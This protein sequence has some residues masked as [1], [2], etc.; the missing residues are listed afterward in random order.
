[1]IECQLSRK[2]DFEDGDAILVSLFYSI[3]RISRVVL[4]N[5]PSSLVNDGSEIGM[6]GSWGGVIQDLAKDYTNTTWLRHRR[7]CHMFA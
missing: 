5:E 1:M 7:W 2:L 6:P 4:A 3:G